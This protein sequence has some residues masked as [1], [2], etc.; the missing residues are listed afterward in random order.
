MDSSLK[1]DR[2][3]ADSKHCIKQLKVSDTRVVKIYRSS[4]S[5]AEIMRMLVI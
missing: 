4:V 1:R 2:E 3:R 5:T